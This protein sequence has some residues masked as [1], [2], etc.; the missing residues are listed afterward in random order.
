MN[1]PTKITANGKNEKIDNNTYYLYIPTTISSSCGEGQYYDSSKYF[2]FLSVI[3]IN[4]LWRYTCVECPFNEFTIN[5][6]ENCEKCVQGGLC[7]NGI[8][9]NQA[10]LFIIVL[11]LKRW[12]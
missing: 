8:L 12:I 10:G 2:I 5:Q 7:I 3:K 9:T 4:Y 6:E 11:N 1:D